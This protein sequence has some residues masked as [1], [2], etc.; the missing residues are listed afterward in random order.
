MSASATLIDAL[1]Q[2]LKAQGFTYA[3]V[4]RGLGM[5]EASVKRMFSRR[6]FTLK[7]LDKVLEL[8]G[9]ELGELTRSIS[10]EAKLISRM[11]A[12]QERTI[13]S[14]KKLLLLALCALNQM[15]LEKII[16][17]YEISEPECIRLLVRLDR[18]GIIRLLAGNRYRL[19][20]SRTFSWLP[21]GPMQQYFK[22]QAQADYFRSRFDGPDEL[23]L[24]VNGRLGKSS[25]EAILSRLRKVAAEFAQ[26]HN[27]DGR[28]S[29]NHRVGVTM[30]LAIRPWQS[31][32]FSALKRRK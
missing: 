20:L 16:A 6:D 15:P 19:L 9:L 4:A 7:R 12:Q 29:L 2:S 31:S 21:D 10:A 1:K 8:A 5:S 11:T 23:M 28:G 30:L 17:T 18:L 13:V 27:D 22:A 14:D 25:R 32:E 3:K 26:A 24:F